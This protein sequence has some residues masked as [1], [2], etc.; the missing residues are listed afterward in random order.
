MLL[1]LNI[2]VDH[3]DSVVTHRDSRWTTRSVE[4]SNDKGSLGASVENPWGLDV[5]VSLFWW[6]LWE[7][8][9]YPFDSWTLSFQ[10]NCQSRVDPILRP[11]LDRDG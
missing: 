9:L 1:G 11:R 2:L 10:Y 8:R 3:L 6:W 4:E 7:G 5:L